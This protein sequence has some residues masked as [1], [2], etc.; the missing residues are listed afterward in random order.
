MVFRQRKAS[1]DSCESTRA[2]SNGVKLGDHSVTIFRLGTHNQAKG[3]IQKS[4]QPAEISCIDAVAN[5]RDP[6]SS[7][8]ASGH[9]DRQKLTDIRATSRDALKWRGAGGVIPLEGA[10]E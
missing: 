7:P 5:G 1:L 4:V 9:R 8:W 3:R 10:L 6:L 2:T